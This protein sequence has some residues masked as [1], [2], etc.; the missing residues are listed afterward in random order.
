MMRGGA[1]GRRG[2]ARRGRRA[3]SALDS[4]DSC[5]KL[6]RCDS[7]ASSNLRS[8]AI[9]RRSSRLAATRC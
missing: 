9:L 8:A 5:S 1:A 3:P 4:P 6:G 7:H 2:G